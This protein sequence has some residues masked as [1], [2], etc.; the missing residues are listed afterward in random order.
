MTAWYDEFRDEGPYQ[1]DVDALADYLNKVAAGEGDM[2]K[3]VN[4]AKWLQWIIDEGGSARDTKWLDAVGRIRKG[5]QEGVRN[6]GL[7]QVEF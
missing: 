6:R 3:A 1:E 4:V 2:N 7:G 5:L